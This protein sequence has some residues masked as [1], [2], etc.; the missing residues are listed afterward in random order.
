VNVLLRRLPLE[1][2]PTIAEDPAAATSGFELMM[3]PP[4]DWVSETSR[5]VGTLVHRELEHLSRRNDLQAAADS[6][7]QSRHRLAIELAELGVPMERCDVA[8]TRV[9]EAIDSTLSDPRG[10][11][12]MG[13]TEPLSEVESEFALSGIVDAKVVSIV[14]DRT[15][16]DAHGT[17][18]IVDFKTS[19]HEGGGL[20]RF[21]TE[22]EERYR[23]QLTRYAQLLQL[24]RPE[25]PIRTA[26]YFPLLQAWREVQI[27]G[28]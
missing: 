8:V 28:S 16:V 2:Q 21:L 26:L 9:I 17:R 27:R 24:F 12:L 3:P 6:L 14:I 25:Q 7:Q 5:H 11:W 4:F 19:T 20:E 13:L 23:L 22:E 10:R 18:W 1:W 15:F